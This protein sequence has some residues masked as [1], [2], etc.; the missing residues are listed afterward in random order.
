MLLSGKFR[1][2]FRRRLRITLTGD[3]EKINQPPVEL[4]EQQLQYPE[5]RYMDMMNEMDSDHPFKEPMEE[6]PEVSRTLPI[7][8]LN[9]IYIG[10]SLSSRVSYLEIQV[11][12]MESLGPYYMYQYVVFCRLTTIQN[13]NLG[14]V[15]SVSPQ[16]RAQQA[17]PS[18]SIS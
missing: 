9:E 18:T 5:Y 8:A 7:L 17:G 1:W 12:N 15:V 3:P 16:G 13:L 2:F 14:T 6:K 11:K 10:E 4:K